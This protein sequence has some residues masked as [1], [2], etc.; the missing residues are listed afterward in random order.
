M[1]C[2]STRS[3]ARKVCKHSGRHCLEFPRDAREVP[4]D[5][6]ECVLRPLVGRGM[7]PGA[8]GA[9]ERGNDWEPLL[10]CL[11]SAQTG[12]TLYMSFTSRG[13]RPGGG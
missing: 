12:S 2:A 11:Y 5:P 7:G 6:G 4:R 3:L 9:G 8:G 10:G 13:R 1:V